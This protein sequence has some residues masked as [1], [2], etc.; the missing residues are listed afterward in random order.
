M[1][2]ATQLMGWGGVGML[3]FLVLAHMFDATQ[4]M[5]WD[6]N[7]PNS[8]CASRRKRARVGV[9]FQK[10]CFF[11]VGFCCFVLCL[12]KLDLMTVAMQ[13]LFEL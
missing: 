10:K 12:N 3:T 2:D 1:L 7:V 11:E 8:T 5:G 13:L 6:V 9:C 4:L